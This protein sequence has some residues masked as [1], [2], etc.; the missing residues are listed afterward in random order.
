MQSMHPVTVANFVEQVRKHVSIQGEELR[1]IV[2]DMLNGYVRKAQKS[3]VDD[4][5]QSLRDARLLHEIESDDGGLSYELVHEYLVPEVM[6]WLDEDEKNARQ[7]R[8]RL[9]QLQ[10]DFERHKLLLEPK[11]LEIV[12]SQLGNP[13]LTLQESDKRLLLLSA[14]AHGI[15]QQWLE[16]SGS[17]GPD[18]LREA[19]LDETFPESV[20]LG[21]ASLLGE[22]GDDKVLNRL[23]DSMPSAQ[24]T[25]RSQ[26]LDLLASYLNKS[27]QEHHFPRLVNRAVFFRLAKLRIKTGAGERARMRRVAA[28]AAP[29]CALLPFLICFSPPESVGSESVYAHYNFNSRHSCGGCGIYFCRDI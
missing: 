17:N 3:F 26:R 2:N 28:V 23:L 21:A 4:V 9:N 8:N 19:C 11:E 5:V 7:L 16:V 29:L 10:L 18:W 15:G 27:T 20:R 13:K 14:A 6:G 25:S 22:M 1:Q 12:R 24:S